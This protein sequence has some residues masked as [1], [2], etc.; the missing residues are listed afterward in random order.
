MSIIETQPW[1]KIQLFISFNYDCRHFCTTSHEF[2]GLAPFFERRFFQQ[3]LIFNTIYLH[4]GQIHISISISFEWKKEVNKFDVIEYE[5]RLLTEKMKFSINWI[6]FARFYLEWNIKIP[7]KVT[8]ASTHFPKIRWWKAYARKSISIS[9]HF[10]H[11]I[12]IVLSKSRS[13]KSRIKVLRLCEWKKC[14]SEE[15]K[16]HVL[17]GFWHQK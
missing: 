8:L 17:I 12:F 14:Q 15:R 3:L 11:N 5:L 9:G 16:S 4:I 10:H 6:C 7:K 2:S 13:S 1:I